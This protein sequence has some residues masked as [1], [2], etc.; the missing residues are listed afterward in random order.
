MKWIWGIYSILILSWVIYLNPHIFH[1]PRGDSRR[2]FLQKPVVPVPHFFKYS[3]ITAHPKI[4]LYRQN[5]QR[6]GI[7][8]DQ[9]LHPMSRPLWR[10][11]D[12]NIAN[13]GASKSSPISDGSSLYIGSDQSFFARINHLGK[14]DWKIQSTAARGIHG[15]ALIVD[16]T[17]FWGDYNGILYSA[18][19]N[20]GDINWLIDLGDTIGSSPNYNRGSVL[21]S[22]EVF[23]KANGFM[24]RVD[25]K[26]GKVIWL[27]PY[28]GSHPHSSPALSSDLNTIY[29]GANSNYLFAIDFE[30]GKTNW[31]FQVDGPIK[32]TPAV[33]KDDIYFGS[34]D[35]YLYRINNKGQ[36]IWRAPVNDKCQSSPTFSEKN[37]L[38]FISSNAGKTFAFNI[39]DGKKVWEHVGTG[40]FMSSPDLLIDEKSKKESVYANCYVYSLC[41]FEPATGKILRQ[42]KFE[43]R[44]SSVPLFENGSMYFSLDSKGGFVK[45]Y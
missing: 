37:G 29:V 38:V 43:S 1:A 6:T 33:W 2:Q 12:F 15:S 44:L 40:N 41:Q 31:K 16:D 23:S 28:F 10:I 13:H 20:S 35:G 34:W 4:F 14:M 36:M 17:V 24:A 32:G 5:Q 3:D 21:V 19:K 45:W 39:N 9:D 42:F 25:A 8:R 30:T 7:F 18:N 11:P 27:S 26:T 22:V